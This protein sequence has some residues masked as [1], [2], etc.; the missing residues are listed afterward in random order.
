M[1]LSHVAVSPILAGEPFRRR[2]W[3]L[4]STIPWTVGGHGIF[5]LCSQGGR[6]S[7]RGNALSQPQACTRSWRVGVLGIRECAG[8]AAMWEL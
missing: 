1:P 8:E 7:E 2:C 5:P 4:S 6:S 3:R